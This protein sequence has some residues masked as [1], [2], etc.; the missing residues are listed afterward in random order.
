M[1]DVK[2]KPVP[3]QDFAA[4]ILKSIKRQTPNTSASHRPPQDVEPL[5]F[6][7]Q[8]AS[9]HGA[10]ISISLIVLY[11]LPHSLL[12]EPGLLFGVGWPVNQESVLV[13]ALLA[14][15]AYRSHSQA[16]GSLV[17]SDVWTLTGGREAGRR[18]PS[19]RVT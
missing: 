9:C 8:R 14:S 17:Q 2:F 3:H 12:H 7:N 5:A 1:P 13:Q 19:G 15:T 11:T 18:E 10:G 6:E 4:Q 16:R